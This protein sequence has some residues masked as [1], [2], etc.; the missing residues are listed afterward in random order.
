MRIS[1]STAHASL[2][3]AAGPI[4]ARVIRGGVIAQTIGQRLDQGRARRRAAPP[5]S[6]SPTTC[7]DGEHI[8]AVDLHPGNAGRHRLL[9]QGLRRR[10]R[11]DGHRDRPAVVDDDEHHRQGARSRQIERLVES[12]LGS[13]AV[14]DVGERAARLLA[15]LEGHR[16]AG[17]MQGL[18]GDRARTRQNRCRGTAKS[19]PRSSPPQYSQDLR[20]GHA[21]PQL[22]A[23]LAIHG[24][25][26]VFRRAWRRR[27]RRAR[28]RGPR[29]EG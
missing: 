6:A 13:A 11:R 10:L 23:E 5:R 26:H 15:H 17:R 27:R 14:A 25:Q 4:A 18:S 16:R 8:V 24:R 9:R 22:R 28:L 12:A 1:G 29:H 20:H 19:L 2:T 7:A 3:S 21:A